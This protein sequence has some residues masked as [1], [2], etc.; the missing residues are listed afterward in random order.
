MANLIEFVAGVV[1]GVVQRATPGESHGVISGYMPGSLHTYGQPRDT[2]SD[3]YGL[4]TPQR[5]REIILKTPTAGAGLNAIIDYCCDVTVKVRNSDASKPAPVRASKFMDDLLK[6]PNDQDDAR[7]FRYK[8]FR[9]LAILG[10]AGVEIEPGVD[11]Y[12]KIVPGS[13]ANLHVLDAGN[14]KVDFDSHGTILGYN[15]LDVQGNPIIGR[16]GVHTFTRDE[17]IFYQRDPRSESRY[18]M[19]RV[20]QLFACSVVE[21]LMLSYIG[22]RFT[23]GNVPFGVMDLGEIN[24]DEIRTAV[25]LWNQQIEEFER[26][27]YRIV[28]TGSKGGANFIEFGNNLS[29]LEAPM[30]L[31]AVRNYILGILGVTV[32]ELGEADS[33]N[34]S[35]GFNLSYTFKMRAIKPLLDV[36]VGKTTFHLLQKTLNFRDLEIYYEDIDSRDELLQGQI[37]DVLLKAGVISINYV[38]NRKG[39]PSIPGGDEPTI[40]LG[41][42]QIPVSLIRDFAE[43]QLDAL[44]LAVLTAQVQIAQVIQQM[45]TP[46]V[47]AE[48]KPIAGTGKP[49]DLQA[50]TSLPLQRMTQPPERFTTPDA[51]G[52][53]SFKFQAPQAQVKPATASAPTAPRGPV[54]AAQRAGARKDTMNGH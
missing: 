43:V 21:A 35:N 18:P 16:D 8:L 50:I 27:D 4:I 9:D 31:S 48:G 26:P 52:S 25:A 30:L 49:P 54:E 11:S 24:E 41:A 23:D 29:E 44:R 20:Q 12:G 32:N 47:D 19:S 5:M 7:E 3:A 33:V 6:R 45:S 36:Y 17:V 22:A 40:N 14:L 15:Q 38:R 2:I 42:S 28:F 1:A 34:K 46:Q 51:K 10:Y 37:D 53:S 39:L 13:V